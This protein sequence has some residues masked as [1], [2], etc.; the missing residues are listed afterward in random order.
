MQ[1]KLVEYHV[2]LHGCVNLKDKKGRLGRLKSVVGKE[3][4]FALIESALQDDLNEVV[5][6]VLTLAND[7]PQANRQVQWLEDQFQSLIDGEILSTQQ[8]TL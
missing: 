4:Q 8:Q 2:R 3:T 1:I 5:F 7:T 6:S